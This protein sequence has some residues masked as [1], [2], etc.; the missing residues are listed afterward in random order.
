MPAAKI[1]RLY[2]TASNASVV[3][4]G[5]LE[6]HTSYGGVNVCTGGTA[7]ASSSYSATLLPANAFDSNPNSA[8]SSALGAAFPQFIQYEFASEKDIVAFSVLAKIAVEAEAPKTM[9]LQ[10]YDTA[11]AT[12]IDRITVPSATFWNRSI[13]YKRKFSIYPAT[14]WRILTTALPASYFTPAEIEFRSTAGGADRT[15]NGGYS[16]ESSN[17]NANSD[18]S[19]AFDNALGNYWASGAGNPQSIQYAFND[20]QYSIVE[21]TLRASQFNSEM[22]S[23]L[24]LQYNDGNGGWIDAD[25]RTGLAAW[26]AGE[27]RTFTVAAPYTGPTGI[28][29]APPAQ[30]ATSRPQVFVCT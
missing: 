19:Y 20:G 13:N 24:K 27:T 18:G 5:E 28:P 17:Y 23:G 30:T 2:I 14:D 25:V 12:W 3:T 10:Y 15:G 29:A 4:V 6:M 22:P 16:Q 7:T 11:S 9:K 1:W 26:S 21:Y 8:W